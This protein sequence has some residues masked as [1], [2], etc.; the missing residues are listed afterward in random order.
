MVDATPSGSNQHEIGTTKPMREGFLGTSK[1]RFGATYIWIEDTEQAIVHEEFATHYDTRENQPNRSAEWRLYY[2]GNPVT[3]LMSAGDS[4]FLAKRK[5]EDRLVFVAVRSNSSIER[6]LLWLFGLQRPKDRFQAL[7]FSS[8]GSEID[9]AAQLILDELGIETE[10]KEADRLD[11]IVS[12]FAGRF[13]TTREFSQLARDTCERVNPNEG[14]D[15]ALEVWLSHEEALFRRLELQAVRER[16]T[17]GF[18][19]DNDVDV[20]GFLKYSLGVQNRRKSRMGRAFEHHL[21]A[22]FD[23]WQIRYVQNAIT[24]NRQKPDFLFPDLTTYLSAPSD[25]PLLMMLGV[26]STCKDRW[27]QI[28]PEAGKIEFKHLA[29]IEPSISEFQ[30]EQMQAYNVQ[31]VVTKSVAKTYTE[32]QQ[33]WLWSIADFLGE[34]KNRQAA[35]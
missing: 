17:A 16:L 35:S 26:K 25:D 31:L 4:L 20:E 29:T 32:K 19:V 10:I 22:L 34:V 30:T 1:T 15:N 5:G 9:F 21:A 33:D 28:L 8:S 18:A 24:E 3:E 13:P 12:R 2:T 23:S 7:E 6:Q 14:P 27:R 11:E